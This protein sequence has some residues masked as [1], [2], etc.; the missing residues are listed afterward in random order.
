MT[1][2]LK[3]TDPRAQDCALSGAAM[4]TMARLAVAGIPV[5]QG[6]VVTTDCGEWEDPEAE[7]AIFRGYHALGDGHGGLPVVYA[8]ASPAAGDR[9]PTEGGTFEPQR[10]LSNLTEVF[11][12]IDACRGLPRVGAARPYNAGP[13]PTFMA[14]GVLEVPHVVRSGKAFASRA[15]GPGGVLVEVDPACSGPPIEYVTEIQI[16]DVATRVAE[17]LGGR[18]EVEWALVEG[19]LTVLKATESSV[20]F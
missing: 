11:A 5:P 2:V 20:P 10:G 18:V 19:E 17:L 14:V 8:V 1:R 4:A 16:R 15:E 7:A 3:L 9:E 12:A 13:F 6:F